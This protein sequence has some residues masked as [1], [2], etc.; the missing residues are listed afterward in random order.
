[1]VSTRL[2]LSS[3]ASKLM[4]LSHWCLWLV[5]LALGLTSKLPHLRLLLP[6]LSCHATW[7]CLTQRRG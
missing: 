5:E 2:R 6:R 7:K 4:N 3:H 1:M